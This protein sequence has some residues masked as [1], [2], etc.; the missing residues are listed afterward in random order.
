MVYITE[1]WKFFAEFK[2]VFNVIDED[3][4]GKITKNELAKLLKK[5]QKE[6]TSDEIDKMFQA[7]DTDGNYQ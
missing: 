5:L 2:K 4:N 1:I 6:A 7:A 3:G